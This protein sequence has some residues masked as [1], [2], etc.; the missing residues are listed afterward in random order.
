MHQEEGW[1]L[2]GTPDAHMQAAVSYLEKFWTAS[3]HR[4]ILAPPTMLLAVMTGKKQSQSGMTAVAS[5][6]T[7]AASSMS[8]DTCTAVMAGKLRPI[9][10]R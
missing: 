4:S 1:C 3:F 2:V 9:T 8:P 6:S 7:R 10:S 5:I